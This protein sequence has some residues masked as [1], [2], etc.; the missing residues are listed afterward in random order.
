MSPLVAKL[1]NLDYWRNLTTKCPSCGFRR[2]TNWNLGWGVEY[3]CHQFVNFV[4]Y[5]VC[6]F[7]PLLSRQKISPLLTVVCVSYMM[8]QPE[9]AADP[10][11]DF[12]WSGEHS[13]AAAAAGPT[14][15]SPARF[16]VTGLTSLSTNQSRSRDPPTNERAGRGCHTAE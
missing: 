5:M 16:D 15:S 7:A 8:W 4:H 1:S 3:T 9:H 6:T 11:V 14:S 12:A 10:G 13:A 2:S